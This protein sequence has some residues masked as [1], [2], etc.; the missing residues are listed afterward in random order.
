M[1]TVDIDVGGTLTD[2]LFTS[3]DSVVSVKVDTT[4]HDLT[5]CLFD[6]LA[7]G[8]TKLDF[9]DTAA[10]LE[11]VELIR[12]STTIT[13]NVLAELRGPRIGLFVSEGHE[14][15]LYG[16]EASSAVLNHLLAARDVIGVNGS[17]TETTIMNAARMLL[18][19][20]VRR[21]CISL[22]GSHRHP[23]RE[24]A[25][26]K[27][28]DQQYPDHFLGS[29]PVLAGSDISKSADD[30]TRAYCSVINAYTHGALAATLFKAED[31]LRETSRYAGSFLVSHINGGVAGIAKTR[32]IDT[33]E[34]GPVLGILGSAHLA[35]IHGLKDVV[36]MDV[37][38]TTA[39]ISVL[40]GG[41]PIYRK[42]SDLFGIPV[43][44]SLPYLRSIALGGGSVVKPLSSAKKGAVQLGPESMGSYPGPACYGLGGDQPTLTD[45]FVTAGL[46]NP[47]YFLGGTKQIDRELARRAIEESV[48]RPLRLSTEE[49]C[50][51][52]IASAF[53]MVAGV[54]DG[55]RAELQRD[56]SRHTLFAYGGN[57]GLFACSVAEMAGLSSV[58]LFSLGPVFSAFGSS[59]SDICHVYERAIAEPAITEASVAGIRK[60]LEEM[61]A[62]GAQDLLGEGIRPENVSYSLEFEVS[63]KGR[64]SV[65]V[66]CSESSLRSAKEFQASL[67]S[68]AG[69][70]R[71][72]ISLELFRLRVKKEMPKAR[73]VEQPL[74]A[75]DSSHARLGK[76]QV[77]W[78]SRGGEANVYRWESL[79]PGNRVEGCAVLEGVNTTYFI[80]DGWTMVI[81][82]Y[83]NAR[84]NR[85]QAQRN[86]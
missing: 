80:P 17:A 7:Q 16:S 64:H 55:A 70:L 39:K 35:R 60:M 14:K 42:P 41:E 40:E 23:K 37:G 78:G 38:G 8:A 45:A 36:A 13:S 84:L 72:A 25:W 77:F 33:L 44:L 31:D 11:N 34:S 61:K 10:F 56:L 63:G 75:A 86:P 27:I 65:P 52:V 1:W 46:I 20:G 21:I 81:D 12:W 15:N 2:G 24:I 62:E 83:G 29:V 59:V 54:I 51:A 73:L 30:R 50:R 19:N 76:R 71:D 18:E 67:A 53:E 9:P 3:G 85:T 5:V 32:A 79:R 82:G 4:P 6:C 74:Q 68:S 49:G 22:Q 26:K 43:E 47:D 58:H 69:E 28:I 48:A 66:A 57:G